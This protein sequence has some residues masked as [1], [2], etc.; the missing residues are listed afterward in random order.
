MARPGER[1]AGPDAESD[2][3]VRL[4]GDL[5]RE[6]GVLRQGVDARGGT[7]VAAEAGRAV[8][9]AGVQAE[10]DGA[11][12]E[13]D[14]VGQSVAVEVDP[15]GDGIGVAPAQFEADTE[16][17]GLR[18]RRRVEADVDVAGTGVADRTAEQRDVPLGTEVDDVD[19]V[20][21]RPL[22]GTVPSGGGIGVGRAELVEVLDGVHVGVG[23]TLCDGLEQRLAEPS[24]GVGEVVAAGEVGVV[25]RGAGARR[26]TPR[27]VDAGEAVGGDVDVAE[28]SVDVGVDAHGQALAG[29]LA[30]ADEVDLVRR[31]VEAGDHAGGVGVENAI[32]VRVLAADVVGGVAARH[33]LP[34]V[35]AERVVLDV[36]LVPDQVDADVAFCRQ[37]PADDVAVLVPHHRVLV[38]RRRDR[39]GRPAV[40]GGGAVPLHAAVLLANF[41]EVVR[42]AAGALVADDLGEVLL[43]LMGEVA[44]GLAGSRFPRGVVGVRDEQVAVVRVRLAL[45]GRAE[46]R[47]PEAGVDGDL[48]DTEVPADAHPTVPAGG[49]V[50]HHQFGGDAV[51]R[52]DVDRERHRRR[53]F[54]VRLRGVDQTECLG[55]VGVL[56][57]VDRTVAVFGRILWIDRLERFGCHPLRILGQ[58]G[59]CARDHET[60]PGSAEQRRLETRDAHGALPIPCSA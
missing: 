18:R 58:H 45:V 19:L 44:T 15:L 34:A 39:R 1:E 21:R 25:A 36:V 37:E 38:E 8:R 9:S 50:A 27:D 7:G 57:A 42:R 6:V 41:P 60:R 47:R 48:S 4:A 56:E 2:Q 12:V 16:R 43:H 28:P 30:L 52:W 13:E 24:G 49:V 59:D 5:E 51:T 11:A 22:G 54:V 32:E 10:L 35:R 14:L 20:G 29:H 3:R 17:A 31:P 55:R 26:S 46:V 33:C 23:H 53:A 40:V